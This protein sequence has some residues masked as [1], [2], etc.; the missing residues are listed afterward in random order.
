M[1]GLKELNALR[2][3][4]HRFQRSEQAIANS[5]SENATCEFRRILN[6]EAD[7][8]LDTFP[9]PRPPMSHSIDKYTR[10]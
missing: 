9:S 4:P 1:G 7:R 8:W 3:I 2:G 5:K 6:K 10:L